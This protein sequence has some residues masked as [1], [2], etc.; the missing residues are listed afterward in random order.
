MV[1][2]YVM[3]CS[4]ITSDRILKVAAETGTTRSLRFPVRVSQ[5]MLWQ[6]PIPITA[7]RQKGDVRETTKGGRGD[8][9][10][11]GGE[12]ATKQPR[13]PSSTDSPLPNP[14]RKVPCRRRSLFTLTL[15]ARIT[16]T[17]KGRRRHRRRPGSGR[18]AQT[19][20]QQRQ[21]PLP[22]PF[23]TW[24]TLREGAPPAPTP[25][26]APARSTCPSSALLA[27]LSWRSSRTRR[28][29]HSPYQLYP[30]RLSNSRRRKGGPQL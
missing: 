19:T 21:R 23:S 1:T 15:A 27:V 8:R 24:P 7:T 4:V 17:Y 12:G 18:E 9:G 11:E 6:D 10:A 3:L 20:S 30:P 29:R 14:R 26:S 5:R 25:V 28:G 2:L 22:K 13:P 16:R